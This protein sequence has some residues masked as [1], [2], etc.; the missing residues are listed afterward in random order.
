M[1]GWMDG[2]RER[3]RERELYRDSVT[4]DLVG[5]TLISVARAQ[6]I[7]RLLII[8]RLVGNPYHVA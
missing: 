3:E 1:N 8:S 7:T 5:V 4:L 2:E 6:S